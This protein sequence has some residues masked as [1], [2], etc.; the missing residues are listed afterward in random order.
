M[1]D[2]D[3]L[4]TI[5]CQVIDEASDELRALSLDI[6]AHPELNFEEV[7]A[8][9]ALTDYLQGKGFAVTRGAFEMPTAFQAVAGSGSPAIAILCE[10][11][12]L[13]EIGHAC[14]HNLIAASGVAAGLA[15]KTVLGQGNGTVVV[16]GSPAEEGG[17]GKVR[18]IERGAFE[19]VDAAMMLHPGVLDAS[20]PLFNALQPL[21]VEFH[22]R[23]AHAAAAPWDGL[24]ALDALVLAYNAVALLRQQLRPDVR[25]HGVVTNGGVK[26][27]II[28]NLASALFYLRADSLQG[29]EE[30]KA[31]IIPC[32]EGAATATGCRL[33]YRWS[34]VLYSDLVTNAVIAAAYV[35]N[36]RRVGKELDGSRP[37]P[38]AASTDMG[39]VS[40][41]LPSI[42]P[43]FAIPATAANHTPG[44]ALAA[45]SAE[46]HA[47]MLDAAKALAMTALD[48][49]Q[50][51]ELLD[52]ARWEFSRRM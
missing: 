35:E 42:H 36:A 45:A 15:L 27:N 32:F 44:F 7:H 29:L 43:M 13:P 34:G 40:K 25:I 46:A 22:G 50:R 16:L 19:R 30:V 10:Y 38:V 51:P 9:R 28:P 11:D 21:E 17:G 20:N 24:N 2:L 14:G 1:A 6:H 47:A 23:N 49:Y 5:A 39:N 33:D 41:V 37:Q 4:K 8:H 12:A 26:P 48:L 31:R 3:L 18:L 52:E